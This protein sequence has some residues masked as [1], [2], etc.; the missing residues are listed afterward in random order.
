MKKKILSVLSILLFSVIVLTGCGDRELKNI[1]EI[2]EGIG[3]SNTHGYETTI[4]I[5]KGGFDYVSY[6]KKVEFNGVS[7]KITESQTTLNEIGASEQ[8]TTTTT[9]SYIDNGHLI[10]NVDG[11]FVKGEQTQFEID[12]KFNLNK[13]NIVDYSVVKED[14]IQTFT[15]EIKSDKFSAFTSANLVG[16][17]DMIVTITLLND[18]ITNIVLEYHKEDGSEVTVTTKLTSRLSNFSVPDYQE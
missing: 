6:D 16:V 4:N 10:T 15:A 13:E 11:T 12:G 2:Y 18:K 7:Y 14:K 1:I 17:Q 8:M 9:T 3:A 5:K